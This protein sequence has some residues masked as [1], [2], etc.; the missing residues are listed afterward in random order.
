[1]HDRI[2]KY[3]GENWLKKQKIEATSEI[4]SHENVDV[5][6]AFIVANEALEEIDELIGKVENVQGFQFWVKEA[7]T[8]GQK[9]FPDIAFELF[10]FDNLRFNSNTILKPTNSNGCGIEALLKTPTKELYIEMYNMK[11]MKTTPEK[12]VHKLFQKAKRKFT[13][14]DGILFVNISNFNNIPNSSSDILTLDPIILDVQKEIKKQ[15]NHGLNERTDAVV[16]VNLVWVTNP[17]IEWK[18]FFNKSFILIPK[19]KHKGGCVSKEFWNT[20]FKV[21]KFYIENLSEKDF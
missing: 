9:S 18:T 14:K 13:D 12:K 6:T 1:M 3:F 21:D 10:C 5:D 19:P 4:L 16:L 2:K 20:I 15:F 11:E 7:S 8:A 17:T